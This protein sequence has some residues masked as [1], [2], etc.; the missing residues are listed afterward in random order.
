MIDMGHNAKLTSGIWLD[1]S[2][3][4]TFACGTKFRENFF[5]S[6]QTKKNKSHHCCDLQ[7]C[8]RVNSM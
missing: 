3:C 7:H 8:Q 2:K 5:T 6:I 4:T 1:L